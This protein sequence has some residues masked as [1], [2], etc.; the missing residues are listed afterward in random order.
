MIMLEFTHFYNFVFLCLFCDSTNKSNDNDFFGIFTFS[1]S[2]EFSM[3]RKY[4]ERLL[5]LDNN[6]LRNK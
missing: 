5:V 3:M 1:H 2:L 4:C 6:S